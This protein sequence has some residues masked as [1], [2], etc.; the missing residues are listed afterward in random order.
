MNLPDKIADRDAAILDAVKSGRHCLTFQ[1]V[2]LGGRLRVQLCRDALQLEDVR[3]G[4][5]AYTQQ[6]IAD[7]LG[8]LLL[9]PK[10][11]D[12]RARTAHRQGGLVK[13][14]TQKINHTTAGYVKHSAAIDASLPPDFD[15]MV[16]GWKS[17]TLS[18]D[19]WLKHR[20]ATNYGWHIPRAL[21]ASWSPV[22]I[23]GLVVAVSDP[24]FL[25]VQGP[26]E[27]H[28]AGADTDGDP[29]PEIEGHGDYSQLQDYVLR[30]AELLTG[31]VWSGV[32][33]GDVYEGRHGDEA[34]LLVSHEGRLHGHRLPGVVA[35]LRRVV[36]VPPPASTR[37]SPTTPPA[38]TS[39]PDATSEIPRTLRRGD[40]GPDVEELQR[41]LGVQVTG[42]FGESTYIAVSVLQKAHRLT[43]DGIV[44]PATR[45]VLASGRTAPPPPDTEPSGPPSGVGLSPPSGVAVTRPT[46]RL[47]S[48]LMRGEAVS[49]LQRALGLELVDGVFGR[50]TEAAVKQL[51]RGRG[52]QDD[53]V[54]G[55][56][57]WAAALAP[58]DAAPDTDPAPRAPGPGGTLPPPRLPPI[59]FR[60]GKSHE[61]GRPLG[62]PLFII[63]HTAE[64]AETKTAAENLQA[65]DA[66]PDAP[67]ASWHYAVDVD[68]ITQSVL[69]EDRAHA[70]GKSPG[71]D[72]GLHIELAGRASQTPEQWADAYSTEQLDLAA[73]LVADM[74]E[75]WSIPPQQIG[76]TELRAS[77]PGICGHRDCTKAWP[78]STNH[79]D[80]GLHFPWERFLE[81]VRDYVAS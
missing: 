79:T 28:N 61:K 27:A 51:Q 8:C 11:C 5:T 68:S 1:T 23:A 70:V 50:G 72:R 60:Q 43:V 12:V 25:V 59:G 39:D 40:S 74:C 63:I 13:P 9:T 69:E 49:D 67:Q 75:R 31:E 2:E 36:S 78:G 76:A 24:G 64:C 35:V 52:L 4:V 62:R 32:D 15:G 71:K 81:R 37:P 19:S 30:D 17:W 41:R 16:A 66:G 38:P 57:T 33:L 18:L 46:L 54:V 77:V 6:Q 53:G 58:D 55:P 80:P 47:T 7:V 26:Y 45:R 65:W 14:R 3:Y 20:M 44:G 73:R 48:P 34:A 42:G 56:Q 21:A 10:L 29:E 22:P